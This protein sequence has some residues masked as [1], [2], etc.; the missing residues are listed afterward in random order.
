MVKALKNMLLNT[1][2]PKYTNGL[3]DVIMGFT[4]HSTSD[5]MRQLYWNYGIVMPTMM[6]QVHSKMKS[7]T[8]YWRETTHSSNPRSSSWCMNSYSKTLRTTMHARSGYTYQQQPR[9]GTAQ[10]ALQRD[11]MA[12]AKPTKY[13]TPIQLHCQQYSNQ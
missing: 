9:H 6:K 1:V 8:W 4:N 7:K 3:C 2:D 5:V 10:T 11:T 13:C 12:T